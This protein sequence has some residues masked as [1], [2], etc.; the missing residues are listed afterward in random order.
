MSRTEGSHTSSAHASWIVHVHLVARGLAF[1]FAFG[2]FGFV[3]AAQSLRFPAGWAEVVLDGAGQQIT[4]FRGYFFEDLLGRRVAFVDGGDLVGT[5]NKSQAL[6]A[7][8]RSVYGVR[9]I[10]V[11]C[12]L[13]Q[14]GLG[15]EVGATREE[16]AS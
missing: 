7:R 3:V 15:G 6:C 8:Q 13:H 2:L 5:V 9:E 10:L 14:E 1:V 11:V 16:L 4:A 12:R